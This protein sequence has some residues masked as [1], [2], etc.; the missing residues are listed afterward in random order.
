MKAKKLAEILANTPDLDVLFTVEDGR[1]L[2][3]EVASGKP[4]IRVGCI[5]F[6]LGAEVGQGEHGD[7]DFDR[8][9]LFPFNAKEALKE[10]KE[11]LRYLSR[12]ERSELFEELKVKDEAGFLALLRSND[13]ALKKLAEQ[14]FHMG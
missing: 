9:T 5:I 2:V 1:D 12:E 13:S 11:L 4:D 14:Y 3:L 8:R 7:Q 6:H 10:A